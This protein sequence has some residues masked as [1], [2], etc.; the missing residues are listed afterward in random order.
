MEYIESGA[1]PSNI[2]AAHL[3]LGYAYAC[4]GDEDSA[5]REAR[6]ALDVYSVESDARNYW[7]ILSWVGNIH[8]LVGHHDEAIDYFELM[9]SVPTST[10][11]AWLRINP[12]YDTLRSHPRFQALLEG[13]Q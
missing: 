9:L 13:E 8:L 1:S 5:L 12:L 2:A 11:A 7:L 4:M 6:E 10:T 3:W